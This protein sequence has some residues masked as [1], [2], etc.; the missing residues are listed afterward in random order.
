MKKEV[1]ILYIGSNL[2]SIQSGADVINSRNIKLLREVANNIIYLTPPINSLYYKFIFGVS[3]SMLNEIDRLL[4]NSKITHVFI[5]Q[6][7]YGRAV[8]HIKRQHPKIQIITFCH[9]IEI[10]YAKSYLKISGIK[11]LPFYLAVRQWE[12]IAI[13][14]SSQIIT[15]N[16]RDA[17]RL[18]EVYGR[19]ATC[20]LPTSFDDKFDIEKAEYII[21]N[22]EIE[23]I[24]Y[25]FVG[26]AFFPNIEGIQ[27]FINNVIPKLPGHLYIIGKGMDKVVFKNLTDHVHILGFVED[28]SEYYYRA[29]MVVSP[30][31][32]GAG[33]KTKTAEALMYGKIVIGTTE[34]FEGY[35]IDDRCM[36]L[37]NTQEQFVNR[38]NDVSNN[39]CEGI[40]SYARSAFLKNHETKS[41][42]SRLSNIIK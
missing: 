20:Q 41:L 7:L 42:V 32:S 3:K 27:W 16:K 38:I 2:S 26:V 12:K 24:D 36:K 13:L 17:Q 6:S 21:R 9:N 22:R 30:I 23:K 34:A 11:A 8:G 1:N 15:L 29:K 33:M 18:K 28:L 37:A 19:E 31:F 39:I 35:D 25:L 10:D 14:N 40:N 4:I 5:S